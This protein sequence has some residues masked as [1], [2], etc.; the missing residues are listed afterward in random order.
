M[1]TKALNETYI[2]LHNERQLVMSILDDSFLNYILGYY[3]YHSFKENNEFFI[4][5]YP[6][7]V[8]TVEHTLDIGIDINQIFFEFKLTKEDAINFNYHELSEFRFEV[9]GVEDFYHDF[10]L[11]NDIDSIITNIENSD[12][13]EVGV[14]ILIE[15]ED[16]ESNVTNVLDYL[17]MK[18]IIGNM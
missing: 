1:D 14:S 9:Y 2:T 11:E 4:E 6:I 3:P 10:Y 15:K 13:Q 18:N 16:L 17:M 7:P 12:E 8:L 5:Y